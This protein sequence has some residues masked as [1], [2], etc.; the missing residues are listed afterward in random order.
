MI[1]SFKDEGTRDVFFSND[2]QR[3]RATCPRMLWLAARDRLDQIHAA[4]RLKELAERRGNRL[5]ALRGDR[6]G[7]FSIRI[8]DQYRV[9]FRWQGLHAA[10]VEIVDYH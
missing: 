8:N 3:A 4:T 6:F 2:T 1:R 5:K 9:C 10:D 7:Q